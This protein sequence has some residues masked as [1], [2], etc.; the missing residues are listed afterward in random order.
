MQKIEG[1]IVL[2]LDTPPTYC[3]SKQD[4]K[5]AIASLK[6]ETAFARNIVAFRAWL[7]VDNGNII[8]YEEYYENTEDRS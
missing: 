2:T 6:F 4:A 1:Y 3:F 8:N 7:Y 5:N